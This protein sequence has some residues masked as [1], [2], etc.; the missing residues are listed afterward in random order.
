MWSHFIYASFQP[1]GAFIQE[2]VGKSYVDNKCM[3]PPSVTI[4]PLHLKIDF[5][6]HE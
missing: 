4:P 6:I 3:T 5:D 2:L 1:G